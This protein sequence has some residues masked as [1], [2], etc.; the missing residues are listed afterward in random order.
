MWNKT[1]LRSPL[2]F[3]GIKEQNSNLLP[4]CAQAINCLVYYC[5]YLCI[6]MKM[7]L[8]LCEIV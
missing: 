5:C 4:N 2:P 7:S 3:K 6:K 1:Y 8:K